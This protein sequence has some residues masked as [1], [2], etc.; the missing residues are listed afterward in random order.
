M[1]ELDPEPHFNHWA[2]IGTLERLL[3]HSILSFDF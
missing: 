1:V 2:V 3:M